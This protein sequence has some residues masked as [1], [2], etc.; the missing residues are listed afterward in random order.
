M[1]IVLKS[2]EKRQAQ[3]L[4]LGPLHSRPPEVRV[5]AG[6]HH[7]HM[8]VGLPRLPVAAPED[9]SQLL[10]GAHLKGAGELHAFLPLVDRVHSLFPLHWRH[11]LLP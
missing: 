8:A 7:I 4:T 6:L 5:H 1:S 3:R 10:P 2:E 11:H 9:T